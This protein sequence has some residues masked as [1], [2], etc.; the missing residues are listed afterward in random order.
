MIRP[1]EALRYGRQIEHS[2]EADRLPFFLDAVREY[3][4]VDLQQYRRDYDIDNGKEVARNSQ[5]VSGEVAAQEI[6]TALS[7]ARYNADNYQGFRIREMDGTRTV[8]IDNKPYCP[9]F[10]GL[11]VRLRFVVRPH[12]ESRQG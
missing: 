9:E 10:F 8:I 12:S 7:S 2:T 1:I 4:M 3:P 11:S 5:V 6:N